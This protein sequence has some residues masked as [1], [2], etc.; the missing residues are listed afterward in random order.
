[1][2]ASQAD[3]RG[4][5]RAR[6]RDGDS[7]QVTAAAMCAPAGWRHNLGRRRDIPVDKRLGG[8]SGPDMEA[9]AY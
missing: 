1:V 3:W 5:S 4:P 6:A 8:S 9:Y 2:G 7:C